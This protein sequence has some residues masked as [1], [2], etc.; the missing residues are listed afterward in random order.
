MSHCKI[1]NF[2]NITLNLYHIENNFPNKTDK[3]RSTGLYFVAG[4]IF[5]LRIVKQKIYINF[6]VGFR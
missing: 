6:K 5:V 4:S 3:N 2:P 1:I